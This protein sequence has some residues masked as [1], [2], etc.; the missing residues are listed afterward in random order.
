MSIIVIE[1]YQKL[2]LAIVSNSLTLILEPM[3]QH[4]FERAYGESLVVIPRHLCS[5]LLKRHPL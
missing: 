2:A 5:A 4:H 3:C 1:R